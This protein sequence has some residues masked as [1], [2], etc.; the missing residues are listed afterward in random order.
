MK[1][2]TAY[3]IIL[4]I[5]VFIGLL[6]VGDP[7]YVLFSFHHWT[8]EMPFWLCVLITIFIIWAIYVSWQIIHNLFNHHGRL[9]SWHRF[10]GV[11]SAH[12]STSEGLIALIQGYWGRAE[13][14]LMGGIKRSRAPLINYLAAAKAAQEQHKTKKRSEYLDKARKYAPKQQLA[15]GLMEAELQLQAHEYENALRTLKQVHKVA[16]RHPTVLQLLQQ[17]YAAVG[18]WQHILK[19]IPSLQRHNAFTEDELIEI[20]AE[21]YEQ[22]FSQA[23]LTVKR[24]KACWDTLPKSIKTKTNIV[25]TYAAQLIKKHAHT[26]AS[27]ILINVLK[28]SWD[29]ELMHL[30]AQAHS[31]HPDQ[32]FKQAQKLLKD[33]PKNSSLL[34]GLGKIAIHN[35][36]WEQA[37]D[38]LQQAIELEPSAEVYIQ[39]GLT[40]QQLGNNTQAFSAYQQGAALLN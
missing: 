31:D 30:Y 36:A 28:K 12:S 5:A 10:R 23:N 19:L 22:Q 7:G 4:I 35:K 32:H 29:D 33:H 21:A 27:L 11:H 26:D 6:V 37:K 39:L 2:L 17:T 34:V 24:L 15:I 9:R 3:I 8:M 13:K 16:P 18:D 20:E 40:Y 1:R 14:L 38:Y 25:K